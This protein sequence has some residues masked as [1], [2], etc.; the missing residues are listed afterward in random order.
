MKILLLLSGLALTMSACIRE[1]STMTEFVV[2]NHSG[3]ELKIHV[4]NFETEFY[5]SV[6]TTFVLPIDSR[7][8]NQY[9]NRGKEAVYD[10]PFGGSSDSMTIQFN[11]TV[12][13]MFDR[14][15]PSRYNPLKIEN[16]SGGKISKGL[17]R[18]TYTFTPEDYL[19]AL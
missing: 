13:S 5:S 17:Y 6:D 19:E 8:T 18:Y 15:N 12:S 9:W 11:D 7:W 4:S 1:Y 10:R 16:Y 3:H 14:D 2:D